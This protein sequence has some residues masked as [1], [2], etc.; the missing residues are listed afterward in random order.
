LQSP[1][2]HKEKPPR[3]GYKRTKFNRKIDL[4][5]YFISILVMTMNCY[6]F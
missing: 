2:G 4:S 6:F 3:H 1:V 5:C